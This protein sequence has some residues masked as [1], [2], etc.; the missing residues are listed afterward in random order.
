MFKWIKKSLKLGDA[1][2]PS[3]ASA[4]GIDVYEDRFNTVYAVGDIHGRFDL[5][6]GAEERI[7]ADLGADTRALVIYLGDYIDR[8][9][10]SADVIEHLLN[11]VTPRFTRLCLRGNHED[12]FMQFLQSPREAE[13][14]LDVAGRETLF[15]YKLDPKKLRD[16]LSSPWATEQ[17][18]QSH[19]PERHRTFLDALPYFARWKSYLFVHAGIMPGIPLHKQDREDLLWIREPFLTVGPELPVTVVHGHTPQDEV[20]YG[21]RRIG[22]DTGA[23]ATGRLSVL[24]IN[25]DGQATLLPY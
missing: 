3:K 9:P 7:E 6:R 19:I 22:I 18:L 1:E 20:S 13:G 25:E 11:P 12:M 2:S 24:K 14:W 10:S 16:S 17:L 21:P 4:I 5:L 23:Y 15:S 8:G